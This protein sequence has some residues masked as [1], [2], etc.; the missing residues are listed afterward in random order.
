MTTTAPAPLVGG[1]TQGDG[2]TVTTNRT[3]DADGRIPAFFGLAQITG[4][5]YAEQV[6]G[7]TIQQALAAAGLDFTVVKGDDLAVTVRTGDQPPVQ[8]SGLPRMRGTVAVYPDGRPPRLL[9]VV[10]SGYPVVQPWEAAEFGQAVLEEG[11]ATVAAVGAYG[12]PTG[13]RMF[14]AL[15]LPEGLRIG[16]EDPHDLYLGLGNSF[17]R[18]TGLWA[19]TAPIR[20]DCT[21]QVAA[22]FGH[23]SSRFSIPHRGEMGTK[24]GDVQ[25]ALR[26]TNTFAEA[27]AAAAEELLATPMVGAEID[28]FL[29][30]LLP[31]PAGVRTKRGEL[32]WGAR[33]HGIATV[34]R[35]GERNTV[36]RGTRYAALQGVTEWVDWMAPSRSERGRF[37]RLVDGGT[38]EGLKVSAARLL[39][40]VP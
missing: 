2:V 27:Y 29:E 28:R 8:V 10:G 7:M 38:H 34:I 1:H 40:S 20:L 16:G 23:L 22:T 5:V 6:A 21:N 11:G 4:G 36:G 33:R 13:S 31:T 15:K 18:G 17:D 3:K 12:D 26:L 35:H 9:G 37:T 32:A 24:V 14:M 19:V 30:T 39:L 25:R